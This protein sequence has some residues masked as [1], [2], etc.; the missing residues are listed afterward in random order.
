MD[1]VK[2]AF[3]YDF[4]YIVGEGMSG[5]RDRL[6]ADSDRLSELGSTRW[7][8]VLVVASLLVLIVG[9]SA[10]NAYQI[11]SASTD[12][13]ILVT[14]NLIGPV[15]RQVFEVLNRVDIALKAGAIEINQELNVDETGVKAR[16]D[17]FL[18]RQRLIMPE[19]MTFLATDES[20]NV[21]YGDPAQI[22]ASVS[23][24]NREYFRY[25]KETPDA[26][27]QVFGPVV[28]R[29]T[30][31]WSIIFAR[32][33]RDASGKFRGIVLASISLDSFQEI[34]TPLKLGR[35][36]AATIRMAD[37]ALIA[38]TH[39]S[40]SGLDLDYGSR[41][42]S[43]ELI[44]EISERPE[45]GSVYAKAAIDGVERLAA[46]KKVAQYPMYVLVGMAPEDFSSDWV[47]QAL[48]VS[49]MGIFAIAITAVGAI[50]VDRSR[51]RDYKSRLEMEQRHSSEL[52]SLVRHDKLTGLPN[53]L[54]LTERIELEVS[55]HL[56][57]GKLLAV[58][59]LDLDGFKAVNDK[60]GHK[61]GDQLLITLAN[62]MSD[63]IRESDLAAR[64][65][66]DEFVVLL[67]DLETIDAAMPI[68][69][70]L[71][72][73]CSENITL[74]EA[75]VSVSA[76]IGVAFSPNDAAKVDAL[77]LMADQAMYDSK[78][79]GGNRVGFF[80][81]DRRT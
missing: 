52:E 19:A 10:L 45:S 20:G 7:R 23:V 40:G 49:L 43:P 34:L 59:F 71:L 4:L 50:A 64:L 58:A 53:R 54:M 12:R 30:K 28:A 61:A 5:N 77:L 26:E 47:S 6:D 62:R 76:S 25:L 29:I 38:R 27:F 11:K 79:A 68:L 74:D 57:Q 66:G 65:G 22:R 67:T 60:Y 15:E 24:A 48:I 78:H 55:R 44:K 17:A 46:Y 14:N 1:R 33:V 37:M 73:V 39:P 35:H 3:R 8:I 70:R 69:N 51:E 56:R 75:V 36:G 13:I 80:H 2:R 81:C 21:I 9:M 41:L 63:A 18:K 31:E 32:S 72:Q 16:I 42:T